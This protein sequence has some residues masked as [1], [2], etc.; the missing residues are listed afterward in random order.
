MTRLASAALAVAVAAPA[1]AQAIHIQAGVSGGIPM[2]GDRSI[3]T[4]TASFSPMDYAMA[5]IGTDLVINE[6]QG[7]L[8]NPRLIAPMD[9][10]GTTA[11]AVSAT[12]IDGIIAGQLNF[13]IAGIYADPTN[14][15]AFWAVDWVYEVDDP[16]NPVLIDVVTRTRRFDVYTDRLL[17]TSE[18]RVDELEEGAL[19]IAVPAPAG[20]L[21]L[22]AGVPL[23]SRRRR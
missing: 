12:G 2:P 10:P 6:I 14:P 11:G 13:P 22:L 4:M 19:L 16:S 5:G 20:W 9:G 3:I 15:I 7:R 8:E 18:F 17:A 23:A 21:P 1:M